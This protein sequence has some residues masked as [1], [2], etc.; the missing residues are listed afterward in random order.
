MLQKGQIERSLMSV[1][2]SLL[3]I[4]LDL[5]PRVRVGG[6]PIAFVAGPMSCQGRP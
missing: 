1:D 6:G 5:K 2:D 4:N 3:Q